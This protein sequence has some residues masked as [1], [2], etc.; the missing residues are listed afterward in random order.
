MNNRQLYDLIDTQSPKAVLDEVRIILD[1]ISPDFDHVPVTSSFNTIVSLFEGRHPGFK[2]C[3]TEYHNLQHTTDTFLAMARLLH[4]AQLNGETF[5]ERHIT[6]GL[7]AALFHDAGF[8]QEVR[9]REGTGA[10][11]TINH[12]ER[13]ADLLERFGADY[14]LSK[15]EIAASRIMI[16]CTD[17]SIDTSTMTFPSAEMEFLSK[18]L[19]ASDLM[20]QMADRSYLEKLLFLYHEFKEANVGG[21]QS[22]LDLLKKTV[23]FYEFV[24]ERLESILEKLD[25]FSTSHFASRWNINANLYQEAIDRQKNYLQQILDSPNSDPRDQL[26]R[27]GIVR[28]F[29]EKYE[30]AD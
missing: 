6:L 12:E 19:T 13:S 14:G 11:Y 17:I 27:A 5:T 24:T 26:K 21:Y 1:L 9:D 22:D 2:A 16:L 29:R 10:K 30:K 20:A 15:D 3:N 8:I 28:K 18:I 4:G 25:K 7:I 23:T